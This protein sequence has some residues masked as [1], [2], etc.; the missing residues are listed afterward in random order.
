M[1]KKDKKSIDDVFDLL[2]KK[3]GDANDDIDIQRLTAAAMTIGVL[4]GVESVL[5]NVN[6]DRNKSEKDLIDILKNPDKRHSPA[7][8]IFHGEPLNLLTCMSHK[9]LQK[10][11]DMVRA[12]RLS[13][14]C[15]DNEHVRPQVTKMLKFAMSKLD[16][17]ATC[18]ADSSIDFRD[19]QPPK[20][21]KAQ[22]GFGDLLKKHWS[23]PSDST[24]DKTG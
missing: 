20:A 23:N 15:A 2:D 21:N 22:K 9:G 14:I 8:K 5:A 18:V 24:D 13:S 3:L 1:V 7:L 4:A 11:F 6:I 17:P 19:K 10:Y 12:E 16:V